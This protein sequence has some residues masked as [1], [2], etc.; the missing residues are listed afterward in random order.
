MFGAG[1]LLTISDK[2]KSSFELRSAQFELLYGAHKRFLAT[3][4]SLTKISC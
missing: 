1:Y 4:L 2:M 3:R